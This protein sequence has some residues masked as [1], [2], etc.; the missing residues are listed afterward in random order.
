MAKLISVNVG[1]PT[2]VN[3]RG[4]TVFTGAWKSPVAGSR[5]VRQ[6]NVD[7]DG[8][9][10]LGGHGGENRAVL[11][12][13]LESYRHWAEEFGRDDL[14]PG[15][16]G[17]NL[18]VDGLP[19]D[20]VCIGD[21][22]RIGAAVFEVTQPRVTC[23][24]A[25]MRIGVPEMA[26][27]LV[28]HRRPG[29]YCRVLTEG[30]IEAGQE[31]VKIAS[32]PEAVTVAEIDA[33]L[34]LPGHPRDVLERA[35]RIPALSP[36]WKT[37]LQNLAAQ[38]DGDS[39]ATGNAGLTA[40]GGPPPGWAGFRPMDVT[41]VA[42]ESS[43]VRSISLAD[44]DGATLPEWLPGQSITV[45]LPGDGD[46]P[47]IRNYSLSN[48]P[49]S[50]VFRISVK[51]ENHGL[52]S[53]FLH[54]QVEPGDRIDV[55]APRGSFFLTDRENPVILLSAGVGITPV[56]AMLHVLADAG[57]RR[58]IWW[59]H[60]ARNGSEHPFR[61]ESVELLDR[62]SHSRSHIFYSRPNPDD[63]PGVDFTDAGRLSIEAIRALGAPRDADAYLCGPTALMTELGAALVD[64]GLDPS[65]VHTEIFGAAAALTP[66]IAAASVPPHLPA[67][68]PGPGP[69]VQFARSGISAPWGPPSN[70]LLEFAETCDVPTRW[71][72]RTGV[73]HNCETA[74]LSGS[75]RYDPEPLEAPA[76]GNILICCAQPAEA[77]V[78]DL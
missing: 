17:E 33:L 10:D 46:R 72:C 39:P 60:G 35:L 11:V 16:L 20:E 5:M 48:A 24:R 1:L 22:Y 41:A 18:T 75:V 77:V 19:D 49:G 3:W 4:R 64:Y 8:Q 52:A 31:I 65:R 70:S 21:R 14:V 62:L 55:A 76:V 38:A 30:E 34:Y 13:Q 54:S 7:G 56:L 68:P 42:E 28:A 26:A 9:G 29:F 45:R 58:Q 74:V 25:G 6:L 59:L 27:L 53:S 2:D 71:S 69:D 44:P 61:A 47:L 51:R 50:A 78:V 32:G 43:T 57:S 40:A 63:R 66:G 37:S 12:Y 15:M 73:C 23:Y 67:G 36:G